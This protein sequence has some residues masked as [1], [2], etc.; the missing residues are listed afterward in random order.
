MLRLGLCTRTTLLVEHHSVIHANGWRW[1]DFLWELDGFSHHRNSWKCLHVSMKNTQICHHK[2]G[3]KTSLV[4]LHP[5]VLH[6]LRLSVWQLCWLVIKPPPSLPRTAAT[7]IRER[8]VQRL[9][10]MSTFDITVVCRNIR[11][12]GLAHANINGVPLGGTATLA[13]LDS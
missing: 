11:S 10:H 13:R 6:K 1:S 5:V 8:D 9:V 2:N 3:W 4:I 12:C 7:S